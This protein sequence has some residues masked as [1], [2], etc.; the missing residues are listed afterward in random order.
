MIHSIDELEVQNGYP[1]IARH[2]NGRANLKL[3]SLYFSHRSLLPLYWLDLLFISL[4]ELILPSQGH[5]MIVEA[6]PK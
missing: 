2:L 4:T 6:Y 3:Q 1:K 5:A